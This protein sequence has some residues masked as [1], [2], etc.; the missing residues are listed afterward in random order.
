MFRCVVGKCSSIACWLA[1]LSSRCF[2]YFLRSPVSSL[3]AEGGCCCCFL[4]FL[5]MI[6][7]ALF[8]SLFLLFSSHD[9]DTKKGVG[10]RKAASLT[11]TRT[12]KVLK[13]GVGLLNQHRNHQLH[14]LDSLYF[15]ILLRTPDAVGLLRHAKYLFKF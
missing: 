8:F 13:Q 9:L 6:Q 4:F 7:R 3:G 14:K 1:A 10:N 12:R 2:I 5:L 15:Y 11:N